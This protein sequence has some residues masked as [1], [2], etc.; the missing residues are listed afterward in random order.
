MKLL[1]QI[2]LREG[3][4]HIEDLPLFQFIRTVQS[5]NDKVVTEK[6]DG[7]QL[8]FGL[9][10][11]GLFTSREGKSSHR[12]RFYSVGDYPVIAAFNGFRGAHGAFEKIESIIRKYLKVGDV[13]ETEVLFGR[14]PNTVTYGVNEKNFIVVLRGIGT[15]PDERVSNLA[16]ALNNKQVKVES[17]I[18]GSPDGNELQ[19]DDVMMLWE[20][21]KV[22][23]MAAEKINTSGTEK[24]IQQLQDYADQ[25]SK[26]FPEL[27]NGD[28]A[29]L[30]LTSVTKD[31][32]AL[33]KSERERVN[34]YIMTKFKLPIK[35]LLLGNF[36]RK[37][38]P[39]LQDP[40]LH[41]SEDIG[42][43][44]VVIR[45]PVTG[46][47]TKIV[48]K[49]VFTAINT[50]NSTVRN[51]ISGLVRTTDQDAPIESRGGVFGQAKIKIANIL[52]NDDL[53]L[54]SAARRTIL[55]YKKSDPV[56]T[57]QALAASLPLGSLSAVRTK[58]SSVLKSA[59][60]EIDSILHK[61]KQ[62][63]GEYK[64]KLKTGKEIGIS[65]EVMKRTLTAFAET[66]KEINEIN[67]KVLA[68]RNGADL[69]SALYGRTINSLFNEGGDVK[70]SYDLIKSI[71]IREDEG[72]DG[73]G[74]AAVPATTA[75]AV[76]THPIRV[77]QN[78]KVVEKRQRKFKKA[79]KFP[80]PKFDLIKRVNEDWAHVDDMKFAT[81][82]GDSAHAAS[83]VEFNQLRNNVTFGDKITAQDVNRYLDKAHEINDQVDS[84]A[85]GLETSDGKVVKVYVNAN[86][87]NEFEKTMSQMLGNEDDV[88]V[89]INT[90][91]NKFD[92][93][94]VEWPEGFVSS[95]GEAA[96]DPISPD[97]EAPVGDDD[98]S[99]QIDTNFIDDDGNLIDDE[100][101]DGADD[102]VSPAAPAEEPADSEV[103]DDD[104][105]DEASSD[106]E[107]SDESSDD[108]DDGEER[109]DFGQIVKKKKK[110]AKKEKPVD[111]EETDDSEDDEPSD[112]GEDGDEEKPT[113]E[114][115][116]P[117]QPQALIVEAEA[118]DPVHPA[119]RVVQQ[120]LESM[121]FDLEANRSFE[122]QARLLRQKNGLGLRAA[123]IA[124]VLSKL[125][126]ANTT[127]Q[128]ALA[129]LKADE[130]TKQTA[131]YELI[132]SVIA[133]G[134]W[135]IG[136]L[137]DLGVQ[138]STRGL[139]I[140]LDDSEAEKLSLGLESKKEVS[141]LATDNKRYDFK[142]DSEGNYS[143]S[144]ED[145]EKTI[146]LPQEDV[147]KILNLVSEKD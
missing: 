88:E 125:Q 133:E 29:E 24:L 65:P 144:R 15:T 4:D 145:S 3:I 76:A 128:S 135:S 85:F 79:K 64:L 102:S 139:V 57:A 93:I 32:R 71:N 35:E 124:A 87:A 104:S 61:F 118:A 143:V 66:K 91:A 36:V 6:L 94:D 22:V 114:T 31:K 33:A 23:P 44:G 70:E 20:F 126:L 81:D 19:V 34:E 38:K 105:S 86:Q 11:K 8:W 63:A 117:S 111:D 43:E 7:A 72:G 47:Q 109:D 27:T 13:V 142:P 130:A 136:D 2:L 54:S 146:L 16:N 37:V 60:A 132:G 67:S 96:V 137:G 99:P 58:V 69:V 129:D 49:D 106:E 78:S 68:S 141:V 80:A 10:E 115:V 48:D 45:D 84:V 116:I 18:V 52:G 17:T 113:N 82:V 103:A 121:G 147:S 98:A 5:I 41:P 21:T 14:Q 107:T 110:K 122:Y 51:T 123:K 73:G 26:M 59:I 74:A 131:G 42:V 108:E 56:A 83:D 95:S 90:L 30:N 40:E 100:G 9:D 55:K 138:I 89:A 140:K 46:G 77:F 127:Y 12:S 134:K 62:E 28:L 92:V 101:S 75:A 97:G 53:A 25:P 112:E 120:I 119:L 50:F 39:M 1:K